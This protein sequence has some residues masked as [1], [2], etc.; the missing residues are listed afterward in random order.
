MEIILNTIKYGD[1]V[2]LIDDEDEEFVT[3]LR[4]YAIYSKKIKNF[5]IMT[6]ERKFLH[7]ILMNAP[8]GLVVHHKNHNT[9]DNRK[10]NLEITTFSKN[11]RES[12]KSY[13]DT[14]KLSKKQVKE[15]ITSDLSQRKL[16]KIYNVSQCAISKI[17]TG[18]WYSNYFPEIIRKAKR[19]LK[20][21]RKYSDIQKKNIKKLIQNGV[22]LD[23]ISLKYNI[24]KCRL[25]EIRKGKVW[26]KI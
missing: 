8:K 3:G 11:N 12:F 22:K 4:L 18:E 23:L 1:L 14:Q 13:T 5:Y 10:C 26:A 19:P 20:M 24:P 7:R 2:I 25:Y 17:R 21:I 15:I 9:L 6:D 16:A